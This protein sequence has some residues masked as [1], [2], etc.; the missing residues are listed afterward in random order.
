M[1]RAFDSGSARSRSGS[2][3]LVA[4]AL[5]VAVLLVGPVPGR[6]RRAGEDDGAAGRC[7]VSFELADVLRL[8]EEWTL[9]DPG[10]L[11]VDH[12]GNIV[13]VDSG[14]H[15][16][17]I[18]TREG[19]PIAEF[20]GHGWEEG[21]FDWPSDVSVYPG[22]FIY[23]LDEGNRRVERFDAD[24]NYVDHIVDEGEAGTPVA[25]AVGPAG[26][27]YLV[28]ADSQTVL[29]R[30]QFD[31][32]LDPV[33]RF[34]SDDGGLVSPRAIAIGPSREIAVA[35]P[36]RFS[37]LVFDEFGSQLYVLSLPDTLI[38]DDV[39]FNPDAC[40]IVADQ[41]RG[42]VLAFAP[43]GGGPTAS[44]DGDGVS[45]QPSAVAL[46]GSDELL[47]LDANARRVFVIEMIHGDCRTGR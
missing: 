17:L 36:G 27:L 9:R 19:E 11:S 31:E 26:A 2:L 46:A 6:A 12:R 47:A 8:P 29:R 37:V 5:A 44:F 22:F 34:G 13:I 18:S 33:G 23:V 39:V 21:Q 41:A 38:A 35:D 40:L 3:G 28:D 43:D 10:A 42:V 32:Q 30:S 4:L 25:M 1:T 24:G 14:N 7:V 15:R 16:V 20:G 45:F